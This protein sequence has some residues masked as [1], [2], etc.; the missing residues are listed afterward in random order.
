[1]KTEDWSVASTGQGMSRIWGKPPKARKRQAKIFIQVSE[2][3][4]HCQHIDLG[5][6]AS[7]TVRQYISVALSHPT[8]GILLWQPQ[9]TNISNHGNPTLLAQLWPKSYYI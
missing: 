8:Y 6:L 2:G 3:A 7:R 1:M 9:E 5:L 4:W